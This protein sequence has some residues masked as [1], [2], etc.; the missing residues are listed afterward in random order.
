MN[1]CR[2][3]E[4]RDIVH[5]VLFG[6]VSECVSNSS[7]TTINDAISALFNAFGVRHQA[8]VGC[9]CFATSGCSDN[10]PNTAQVRCTF[11][12]WLGAVAKD[13]WRKR[14]SIATWWSMS[15][16][17]LGAFHEITIRQV[18]TYL[19]RGFHLGHK[20]RHVEVIAPF[21]DFSVSDL[22]YSDDRKFG[23]TIR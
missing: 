2:V 7:A 14:S 6:A 13:E 8:I 12:E 1:W 18:I 17:Y 23:P 10:F 9:N 4:D 21:R 11:N 5:T 15:D 3:I 20:N 16:R 19:A 22:K